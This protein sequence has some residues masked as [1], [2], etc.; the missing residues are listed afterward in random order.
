MIWPAASSSAT[1]PTCFC[2]DHR[3]SA[4]R[5]WFRPLV[6]RRSKPAS[7]F[8][9]A[10]SSTWPETFWVTEVTER[11][12]TLYIPL[13]VGYRPSMPRSARI[14]PGG[15]VHHVVNRANGRLRLFRKEA[16]FRAFYDALLQAHARHPIRILAW[17][18]LSNHWHFV[19]WPR[20]DGELSQFFGRLGLIHAT[21][22]QAAHNAVG[23][24][25][26]Y[27]GRFKN[28]MVQRDEHLL[29]VLRYVE[30]NPLRPASSSVPRTGHGAAC[31]P[32]CTALRKFATC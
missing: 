24:G 22:W 7:W 21:R 17:C 26:V 18:I 27:Q 16:D 25:H 28:F 31:T 1:K 9:I 2:W 5:F 6:I 11:D 29:W 3:E 32:A 14:A 15:F 10:R 20:G 4:R 19:V 30:R 8:C 13:G 23:M 12:T